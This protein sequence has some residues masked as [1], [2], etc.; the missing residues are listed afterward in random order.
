[1][2]VLNAITDVSKDAP[3]SPINSV[4]PLTS[5]PINV[6]NTVRDFGREP[7]FRHTGYINFIIINYIRHFINLMHY[8][9][10][11]RI[12]ESGKAPF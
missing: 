3:P 9:S 5:V 11:I 12:E 1:M 4:P 7:G 2:V 10:S 8:T 6:S